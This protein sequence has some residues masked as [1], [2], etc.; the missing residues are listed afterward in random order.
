MVNSDNNKSGNKDAIPEESLLLRFTQGAIWSLTS[1]VAS[2]VS[3]V[4][5]AVIAARFLGQ[6]GFGELAMIQ[7]TI[8]LLGTFAGFGIGMTCTKYVA[9]LK[10]QDPERTGRIIALTYLISWGFGGLVTL[11]FLGVAPW[12]AVQ[13]INAP[14][15]VPELRL[16][17]LL[18]LVSAICGPQI[19]ILFGFQAFRAVARINWWQGLLSL[20]VT[21]VLVW[22][23]GLRGMIIALILSAILGAILS[24]MALARE[25]RGHKIRLN[26]LEA[27]AEKKILW[28]FSLPA[29]FASIL[30]APVSWAAFAIL[31]NQPKGYAELGLFNAA[32][33]F[34]MII[35][36][37]NTILAQVMV[38]ML[39]EIHG[40][41]EQEKFARV[42]NLNLRI[43]WGLAIALGFLAVGLSPWLIQ[44]FGERFH[45]AG[46][47]LSLTIC[48]S[49][50]LAGSSISGQVFYSSGRMWLSFGIILSW[51]MVL[52]STGTF[53]IPS[54]G[55]RG[56]ALSFLIAYSLG[57][58]LQLIIL[59]YYYGKESVSNI[60]P[61]L[62]FSLLLIGCGMLTTTYTLLNIM[63]IILSFLIVAYVI[64]SNLVL[65]NKVF[66]HY[67]SLFKNMV[68]EHYVV[69]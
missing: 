41:G 53:L 14:H 28:S 44:I 23:A 6:T 9:E 55:A 21:A 38:P 57:L 34:R 50:I 27:L 64:K 43:T 31:A 32:I 24:S 36:A 59:N 56:L 51:G 8:G 22:A 65:F 45:A 35:T 18:F 7:S 63:A 68:S 16:G 1:T 52:L 39:A 13:T 5:G 40:Q 47:V 42:V 10:D 60:W 46:P 67:L 37:L 12:L 61:M 48:Y 20:P 29:Y 17:A 54:M 2:R 19:G 30:Y 69:K 15:L 3:I 33:Q 26:F 4:L 62:L 66:S 25:Y 11:G 49:V 58:L